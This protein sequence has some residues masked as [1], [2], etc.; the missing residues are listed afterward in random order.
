MVPTVP[1]PEHRHS[2]YVASGRH[3][4]VV[5]SVDAGARAGST[6]TEFTSSVASGVIVTVDALVGGRRHVTSPVLGWLRDDAVSCA[7]ER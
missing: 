5:V 6:T 1:P 7:G 2:V 4:C 3:A